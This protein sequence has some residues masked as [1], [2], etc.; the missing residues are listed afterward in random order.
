V[1]LFPKGG[2]LYAFETCAREPV[3]PV[4]ESPFYLILRSVSP[5]ILKSEFQPCENP[6]SSASVYGF[7]GRRIHSRP[8]IP[9]QAD[10]SIPIPGGAFPSPFV[11]LYRYY[12]KVTLLV[13]EILR[14]PEEKLHSAKKKACASI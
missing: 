12:E 9:S 3:L 1:N 14:F 6:L 13:D 11:Y 4:P 8:E 5:Q 2:A 7:A 10:A